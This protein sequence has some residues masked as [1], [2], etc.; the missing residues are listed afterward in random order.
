TA[1]FPAPVGGAAGAVRP[2]S[3]DPVAL[4][5]AGSADVTAPVAPLVPVGTPAPTAASSVAGVPT[6]AAAV[7]A[8]PVPLTSQVSRTLFTLGAAA[9]GDH[10]MTIRVSP[11]NLGPITVRAQVSVD[12]I[13]VELIAPTD[14]AR[15]ALRTILPD[16][17]RDLTAGGMSAQLSLSADDQASDSAADWHDRTSARRD[18]EAGDGT[19]DASVAGSRPA[20]LRAAGSHTIDVFA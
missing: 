12:G 3:D 9:N 4:R 15:D 8:L 5:P 18:R 16:L 19:A 6:P 1:A 13:R 17:R 20:A 2:G 11:D 7:P 10:V 14:L